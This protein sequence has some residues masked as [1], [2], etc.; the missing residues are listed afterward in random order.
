MAQESMDQ[1]ELWVV[2]LV[3]RITFCLLMAS[4]LWLSVGEFVRVCQQRPMTTPRDVA[5]ADRG[6]DNGASPK[7]GSSVL[8][9]LQS[10]AGLDR[11]NISGSLGPG[12]E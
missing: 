6:A 2:R 3:S 8:G 7:P 10:E 5:P 4:L 9:H 11:G 1:F 12:K